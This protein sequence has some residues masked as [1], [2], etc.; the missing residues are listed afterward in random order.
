MSTITESV[1]SNILVAMFEAAF[2]LGFDPYALALQAKL[3]VAR[4]MDSPLEDYAARA[5]QAINESLLVAKLINRSRSDLL[6][7]AQDEQY[8]RS[9]Q[10]GDDGATGRG[11]AHWIGG[12]PNP[13]R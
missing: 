6:S 12:A 1:Y 8:D 3:D 4:H 2:K 10:S 9:A 13:R 7:G 5:D 11:S